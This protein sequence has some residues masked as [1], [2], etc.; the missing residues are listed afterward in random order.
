MTMVW[1]D[2]IRAKAMICQ[3]TPE[4]IHLDTFDFC[5]NQMLVTEMDMPQSLKSKFG[6]MT[7]RATEASREKFG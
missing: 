7:N 6:K 5:G 4:L 2:A 1:W 3:F